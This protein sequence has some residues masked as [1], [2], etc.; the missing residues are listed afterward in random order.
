MTV[1]ND[2]SQCAPTM[3]ALRHALLVVNGK[4]KLQIIV[5][6]LS[7]ARHFRGLERSVPGISTKVLA[8]ELKDLEAHQ[9]IARTVHPGPPV[10]VDYQLLPYAH[11]L[12]PVIEVLRA[13]GMQ[14]QQRLEAAAAVPV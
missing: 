3:Q 7:G 14:H 10:V 12:D 1:P 2:H 13:W 8:K 4:W 9:F 6:L 11:S 5:A